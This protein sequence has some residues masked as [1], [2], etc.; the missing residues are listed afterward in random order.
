[1]TITTQTNKAQATGNGSVTSFV[2]SFVIQDQSHAQIYLDAVL[3]AS[4]YTVNGIGNPAGAT[5][6]APGRAPRSRARR[7]APRSRARR[8][9]LEQRPQRPAVPH[10]L[11]RDVGQPAAEGR[12]HDERQGARLQM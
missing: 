5:R 9:G 1:M 10:L 3:Q 8:G 4:G 11:G 6:R 2:Y 7:A 12:G